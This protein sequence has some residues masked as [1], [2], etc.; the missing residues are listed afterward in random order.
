[1][2]IGVNNIVEEINDRLVTCS[3]DEQ[4]FL[5]LA[6]SARALENSYFSVSDENSLPFACD[7]IGRFVYVESLC[8]YR[9]SNGSLW[10][11]NYDSEPFI[12][13][14]VYA[15]GRNNSVGQLGIGCTVNISSPVSI[16]GGY[17]D[18][19]HVAAGQ[20]N[21]GAI[22]SNGTIWMWGRG[23]NGQIGDGRGADRSSPT[24]I[25][26]GFTD[27]CGLEIGG[28][29]PGT[30]IAALRTN[31]SLWVWGQNNYGLG[32][33]TAVGGAKS[34]PVSVVGGF[35]WCRTSAGSFHAGAIRDDGTIWT[36][37]RGTYGALG[38][39]STICRS[40]PISVVG[41]FTDWCQ[42]SSGYSQTAAI[43]TDGT[44]WSW[45]RNTSGKLGNGTVINRSSP[46][47]VVGGFNDWCKVS[48][49]A[50][51]T[52]AIRLDGSLWAWGCNGSGVLGDGTAINRSSPVS[53]VGGYNDWCDVA[54]GACHTVAVRTNGTLWAWGCSSCGQLG[55]AI[56]FNTSSPVSVVGGIASW[57]RV[58]AGH[59]HTH[60]LATG[61]ILRGFDTP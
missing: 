3:S 8:D 58:A 21:S 22:R 25:A 52:T 59:N 40:S 14:I 50:C 7:N 4:Q 53:V 28:P 36:W 16:V 12:S 20:C 56:L 29:D 37:G 43:R 9:Y 48:V 23:N 31:G 11:R 24:S 32:D 41:G 39:N 33:G 35:T 49:G 45:G 10:T 17:T 60:A 46:V 57:S 44:L 27:W 26:G 1:M 42:V 47:S 13:D 51:H 55:T 54:V 15:F 30:F 2:S 6:A 61:I 5:Q 34:S 18:W 19:C 38:N